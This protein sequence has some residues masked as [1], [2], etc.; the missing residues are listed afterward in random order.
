VL[1][2]DNYIGWRPHVVQ[3]TGEVGTRAV[4]VDT[5]GAEEVAAGRLPGLGDL[6]EVLVAEGAEGQ[7]VEDTYQPLISLSHYG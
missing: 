1:I 4:L 3:R 6:Q 5:A 2:A 7:A